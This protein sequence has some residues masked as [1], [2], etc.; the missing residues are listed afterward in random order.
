M[1]LSAANDNVAPVRHVVRQ[2][3]L[4]ASVFAGTFA[5]AWWWLN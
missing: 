2:L 4:A 3:L 1:R 5:L